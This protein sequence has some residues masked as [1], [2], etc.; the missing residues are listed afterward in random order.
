MTLFAEDDN[1]RGTGILEIGQ[2]MFILLLD[3]LLQLQHHRTGGINNL[4]MVLSRQVVGFWRLTMCAQQHLHAMQLAHLLM[5]NGDESHLAQPLALHT[6]M[7]DITQAIER[8]T[9]GQFLLCLLDGSSHT[10]A[11]TTATVYLDA[12]IIR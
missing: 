5:V 8:V 12:K 3:A 10:K 6:I 7:Y 1:L 4:D 2:Y 11:E 9:L